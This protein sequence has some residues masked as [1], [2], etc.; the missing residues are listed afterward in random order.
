MEIVYVTVVGAG[1]GLL[2]RYLLPNRH[3]YGLLLTPAVGA[4]ATA[5]VWAGMLWAGQRFDGG[6]IWAGALAAGTIAS[7]LVA[8]LVARAR[9]AADAHQLH[10][11]SGGK[12]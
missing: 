7:L 8:L 10:V 11:L 2:L 1:I 5:A 12:A 3:A 9:A 6:W 4:A